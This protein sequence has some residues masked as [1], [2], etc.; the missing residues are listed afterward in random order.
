MLSRLAEYY[1]FMLLVTSSLGEKKLPTYN[2][3]NSCYLRLPP[4]LWF[5]S[6]LV[7]LKIFLGSYFFMGVFG[8]EFQV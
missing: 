8:K 4:K 5:K 6:F 7:N 3:C 2:A 1:F